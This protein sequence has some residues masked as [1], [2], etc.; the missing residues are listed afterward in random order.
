MQ[1]LAETSPQQK[2]YSL[3]FEAKLNYWGMLCITVFAMVACIGISIV[4][5]IAQHN[6][7]NLLYIPVILLFCGAYIFYSITSIIEVTMNDSHIVTF[8]ALSGQISLPITEIN[9]IQR[10][11]LVR[12]MELPPFQTWK[13][14]DFVTVISL[15]EDIHLHFRLANIDD[16]VANIKEHNTN[17][18]LCGFD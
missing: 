3:Q 18:I 13:V 11:K 15:R 17:V 6:L 14:F 16:L 10:I 12:I 9:A 1:R 7:Y 5:A 2:R 4:L 8:S